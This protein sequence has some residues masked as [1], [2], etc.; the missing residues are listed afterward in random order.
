MNQIMTGIWGDSQE[1][2]EQRFRL[3]KNELEEALSQLKKK[4]D[5]L[6]SEEEK[7][8]LYKKTDEFMIELLLQSISARFS[9]EEI[10][11]IQQDIESFQNPY[12]Q[13]HPNFSAVLNAKSMLKQIFET[14]VIPFV[15]AAN[16]WK[17]ET[18]RPS[19][20]ASG[21]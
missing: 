8:K 14:K 5:A 13:L 18:N 2:I 15:V 10:Q 9:L 17:D 4:S 19:Q 7:Q 12:T 20:S 6:K 3:Q 16:R 11:E 1:E 21:E